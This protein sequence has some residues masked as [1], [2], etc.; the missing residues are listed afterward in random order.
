MGKMNFVAC[1]ESKDPWC[2]L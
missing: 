1:C 2:L